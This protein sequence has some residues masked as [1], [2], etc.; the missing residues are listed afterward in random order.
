MP[1]VQTTNLAPLTRASWLAPAHLRW[2]LPHR[3]FP[4][5]TQSCAPH[6]HFSWSKP[7]GLP[8]RRSRRQSNTISSVTGVRTPSAAKTGGVARRTARSTSTCRRP[9][10]TRR[11]CGAGFQAL[12][13]FTHRPL[14]HPNA[15]S[16]E[17]AAR[18]AMPAILVEQAARLATPAVM[19]AVGFSPSFLARCGTRCSCGA[20]FQALAP[21]THRPPFHPNA[22][23]VEQ[24]ARLATPAILVEQA[25]RLAMPA[26]MPAVGFSPSFLARCGTRRSCGTGFPALAPFTHRP[27][28]HPNAPPVEQAAR[29]AMPAVTP[30]EQHNLE[31]YGRSHAIRRQDWRRGTQD[32]ALH[33]HLPPP[34]WDTPLLWGRLSSLG[35][36]YPPPSLP[37]NCVPRRSGPACPPPVE[38][39]RNP[40][41]F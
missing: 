7:P 22:P 24:A 26:V 10:G 21:F 19:P 28:F 31:R 38:Q 17:Q 33:L 35:P 25:S 18:L 40:V 9:R 37:P 1:F 12:A 15:P 32:C 23:P 27:L 39:I 5:S 20:G 34:S 29:L 13:P 3:P 14:F 4:W 36:L 6:R 30:A 16:V 41:R 2:D 11:S 8:R